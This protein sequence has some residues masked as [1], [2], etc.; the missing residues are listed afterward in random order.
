[1]FCSGQSWEAAN[2]PWKPEPLP[3]LS[4]TESQMRQASHRASHRAF[5]PSLGAILWP[6]GTYWE[7]DSW[8]PLLRPTHPRSHQPVVG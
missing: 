6:S 1:M 8:D 5:L 2:Q 4:S 7:M 3:F